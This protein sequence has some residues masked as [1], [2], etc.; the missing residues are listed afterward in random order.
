MPPVASRLAATVLLFYLAGSSSAADYPCDGWPTLTCYLQPT[1]SATLE[2]S[3]STV[4]GSVVFTPEEACYDW[5]C[6]ARITGTV[7]GLGDAT[8]HGWHI[9]EF[10]DISAPDG[11]AAG[12]HFNPLE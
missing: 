8:P 11:T 6:N 7:S 10:G 2:G 4:T 3:P 5:S 9:H 12:G 1:T